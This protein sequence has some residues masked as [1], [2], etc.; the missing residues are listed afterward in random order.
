M[1]VCLI[2]SFSILN[3]QQQ[4]IG[5]VKNGGWNIIL[6]VLHAFKDLSVDF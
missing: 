2:L 4:L 6:P 5:K 1:K 3:E